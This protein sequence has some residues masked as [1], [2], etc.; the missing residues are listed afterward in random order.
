MYRAGQRQDREDC[1]AEPM[2]GYPTG[3]GLDL[4][5]MQGLQS[6]PLLGSFAPLVEAPEQASGQSPLDSPGHEQGVSGGH[7]SL[8]GPGMALKGR[9]GELNGRGGK[10]MAQRRLMECFAAV[11]AATSAPIL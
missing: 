5:A 6:I 3:P 8:T 9:S 1:T 7:D 4:G 2:Q 11:P 10:K